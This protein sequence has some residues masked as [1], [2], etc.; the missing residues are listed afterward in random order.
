[1]HKV[2][3]IVSYT[4]LGALVISIGFIP[5]TV[6]TNWDWA[7][8]AGVTLAILACLILGVMSIVKGVTDG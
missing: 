5:L 7:A 6:V 8:Y 3:A 1:M 4:L 2:V